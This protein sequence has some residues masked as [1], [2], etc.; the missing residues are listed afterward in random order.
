M[1]GAAMY[2]MEAP[3][4]KGT[5]GILCLSKDNAKV[6]T[7]Q[8]CI[9]CGKCVSVCPQKLL[10]TDM[11]LLIQHGKYEEA[12]KLGVTRDCILCGTCAYV[13]PSKRNLVHWFMVGRAKIYEMNIKA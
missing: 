9:S 7:E 4:H 6:Y 3:V 1:M 2:E 12:D 13:C 11:Q 8:A 10:P 5:S